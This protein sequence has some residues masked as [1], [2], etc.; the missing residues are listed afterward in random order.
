MTVPRSKKLL[1]SAATHVLLADPAPSAAPAGWDA[2]ACEPAAAPLVTNCRT[3]HSRVCPAGHCQQHLMCLGLSAARPQREVHSGLCLYPHCL[4]CD[5]GQ[6][7]Q[8]VGKAGALALL[9]HRMLHSWGL[10]RPRVSGSSVKRASRAMAGGGLSEATR[11]PLP[12]RSWSRR[13]RSGHASHIVLYARASPRPVV[14][15][16]RAPSL[17][18]LY[19]SSDP[20]GD[21]EV[22]LGPLLLVAGEATASRVG[23][24]VRAPTFPAGVRAGLPSPGEVR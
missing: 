1:C 19:H 15:R 6:L 12:I 20:P 9:P 24:S 23:S 7:M 8:Q 5:P 14:P 13:A 3:L 17:P 16:R 2:A 18:A 21:D 22:S 11:G 10:G 4:V